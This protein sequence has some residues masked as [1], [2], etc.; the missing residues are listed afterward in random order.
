MRAQGS[1]CQTIQRS[2]EIFDGWTRSTVTI[3]YDQHARDSPVEIEPHACSAGIARATGIAEPH[4]VGAGTSLGPN[5]SIVNE[6]GNMRGKRECKNWL[7]PH[8]P[9]GGTS[10]RNPEGTA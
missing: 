10:M 4:R 6:I 8:Q 7:H 2:V 5:V 9:L 1:P 3:L